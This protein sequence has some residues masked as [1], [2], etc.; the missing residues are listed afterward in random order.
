MHT[1]SSE[2]TAS[3]LLLYIPHFMREVM[4]MIWQRLIPILT[5]VFCRQETVD[6]DITGWIRD[7]YDP[8]TD[9]E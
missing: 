7:V 5:I 9:C 3:V 8:M 6:Q 2:K 4:K 1:S